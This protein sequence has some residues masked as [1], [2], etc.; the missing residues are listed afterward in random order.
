MLFQALIAEDGEV[1][2]EGEASGV[3][4]LHLFGLLDAIVVGLEA[5]FNSLLVT[6]SF[7]HFGHISEIVTLQFEE[8]NNA[9][10]ALTPFG[11]WLQVLRDQI[12]QVLAY[13]DTFVLEAD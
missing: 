10:C 5:S 2:L 9:L 8:V 4:R 13:V 11:S 12:E 6:L 7:T 3:T 1:E